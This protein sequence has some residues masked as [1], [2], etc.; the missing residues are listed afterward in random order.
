MIDRFI[1]Y[2]KFNVT[3]MDMECRDNTGFL[4]LEEA[5]KAWEQEWLSLY[6]DGDPSRN[7]LE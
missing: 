1:L 2:T 7:I 4:E 5:F 3:P 6:L